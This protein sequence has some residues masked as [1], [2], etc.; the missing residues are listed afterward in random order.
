MKTKTIRRI[1]NIY[2]DSFTYV[3]R[4][5]SI[6]YAKGSAKVI[7]HYPSKV[8]LTFD[9]DCVIKIQYTLISNRDIAKFGNF[10]DSRRF[11]NKTL[12][13]TIE[14]F[15]LETF[16]SMIAC[17]NNYYNDVKNKVK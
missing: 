10:I 8:Y 3:Y 13:V 1:H 16:N 6:R 9:K 15:T 14:S 12:V 5:H 7:R 4:T 2:N 17:A 11:K